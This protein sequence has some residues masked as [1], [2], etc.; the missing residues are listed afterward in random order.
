VTTSFVRLVA[1]R[2]NSAAD[3]EASAP[4]IIM[5]RSA[6]LGKDHEPSE[7]SKV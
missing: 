6:D 1:A 4:D 2:P 5:F 7:D 3:V